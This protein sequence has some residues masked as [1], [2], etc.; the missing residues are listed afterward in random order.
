MPL[1]SLA[2]P[3][4]V[5]H[6]V[7]ALAAL[8]TGPFAL[9]ARKGSRLHRAAG[10]AWVTLMLGTA[11]SS[12]FIRD[13]RLPNLLGYTPIHL[14]TLATFAG[15]A[16]ALVAVA[17]GRIAI[18]RKAMWQTYLGGCVGAGLLA[19]LPNRLLG[20]LVWHQALGLI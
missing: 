1:L 10:Y 18:H 14:L 2:S 17:R 4:I 13:F 20:Q 5:V 8:I 6:L 9:G 19:L 11:L 3:T 15:I 16:G 7:L 12:L